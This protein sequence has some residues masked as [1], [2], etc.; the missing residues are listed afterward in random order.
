MAF[1]QHSE[2]SGASCIFEEIDA[3]VKT[4]LGLVPLLISWKSNGPL[5]LFVL[6]IWGG[7]IDK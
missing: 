6:F 3:S 4:L 5:F 2:A 1:L 7:G